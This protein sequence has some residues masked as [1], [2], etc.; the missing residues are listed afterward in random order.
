MTRSFIFTILFLFLLFPGTALFAQQPDTSLIKKNEEIIKKEDT[1][2][3]KA[4]DTA[5]AEKHDTIILKS[6]KADTSGKSL[7]AS[8][9]ALKKFNP[10]TAMLRSAILPGWGQWY[11][12]KY[13]KIPIIYGALG[14]TAYVFFYNLNTYK[15]LRNAVIYRSRATH[16]DSM[17]VAPNLQ[18]LTNQDL[19]LNRNIFRQN[20]DYSVLVFLGFW[21]LNVVDATV[22][23]H[24]KAFDVSPDIGMKIQPGLSN[25]NNPGVSFVFFFKEKNSNPLLALP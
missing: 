19:R 17:R 11:N 3:A 9:T 12:K 2:L 1:T 14:T 25:M 21:A 10:K 4:T 7:L 13:W 23:A 6:N 16:A 22:D 18:Y 8:D 20:I 5:I 24:L 15:D